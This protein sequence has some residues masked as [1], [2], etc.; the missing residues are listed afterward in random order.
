MKR[1]LIA[2]LILLVVSLQTLFA[3]GGGQ[4]QQPVA[5]AIFFYSP[6]CPHCETVMNDVIPSLDW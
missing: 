4:A 6:S 1:Y 2:V 3:A 5:K